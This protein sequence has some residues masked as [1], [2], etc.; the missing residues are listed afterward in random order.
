MSSA[1]TALVASTTGDAAVTTTVS[2]TLPT[3]RVTA[4]DA[5]RPARTRKS[6]WRTV[7][8]PGSSTVTT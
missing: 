4:M 1:T 6:S 5:V 7:W 3:V 8:N 2:V